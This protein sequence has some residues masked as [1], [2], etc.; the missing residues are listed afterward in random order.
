MSDSCPARSLSDA[1]L[2]AAQAHTRRLYLV[3]RGNCDKRYCGVVRQTHFSSSQFCHGLNLLSLLRS[4]SSPKWYHQ[5]LSSTCSW[6][7][8][9]T[10]PNHL[11][12]PFL[13]LYD[14]IISHMVCAAAHLPAVYIL[15]SVASSFFTWELVIGTVLHPVQLSWLNSYCGSL[16]YCMVV[17]FTC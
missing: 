8:L 14:I 15:I 3:Q 5:S 16:P 7:R 13:H 11:S 10:C 9:F 12:L 6:Y 2:I 1:A 17:S 4:S